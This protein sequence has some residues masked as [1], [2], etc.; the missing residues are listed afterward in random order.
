M[1]PGTAALKEDEEYIKV[2]RAL[3]QLQMI[4]LS[5][6]L[7]DDISTQQHSSL[8]DSRPWN[9]MEIRRVLQIP[10]PWRSFKLQAGLRLIVH[11]EG[12]LNTFIV[13][14]SIIKCEHQD[15]ERR[16]VWP[17]WFETCQIVTN[18]TLYEKSMYWFLL[19]K[20]V[21]IFKVH[22]KANPK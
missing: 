19:L 13:R 1:W 20:R 3:D 6:S 8:K 15:P 4:P 17:Y 11:D 10:W 14:S 2:K 7:Q 9:I 5:L 21:N 16:K 22:F 18:M 12:T